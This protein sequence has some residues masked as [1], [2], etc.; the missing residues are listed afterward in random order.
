MTL[1]SYIKKRAGKIPQ[2]F[3]KAP[4]GRSTSSYWTIDGSRPTP[5][6]SKTAT[7]DQVD[8]RAEELG[9]SAWY[10]GH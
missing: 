9:F 10:N 7:F 8:D 3:E 6:E 4:F 2:F 5:S 1:H